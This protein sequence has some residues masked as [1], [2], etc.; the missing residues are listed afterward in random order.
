MCALPN[1]SHTVIPH[2]P[3]QTSATLLKF[4]NPVVMRK[5]RK[6]S[7]HYFL[8]RVLRKS[9]LSFS[10]DNERMKNLLAFLFS[11]PPV[12]SAPTLIQFTLIHAAV[13]TFSRFPTSTTKHTDRQ[14][15]FQMNMTQAVRDEILSI[16][17]IVRK[18]I[19]ENR[20]PKI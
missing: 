13:P 14:K 16:L 18:L 9:K 7:R 3:S 15:G 5:T 2:P 19:V 8:P 20:D 10:R 17:P 12:P 6:A 11:F 4:L 1:A